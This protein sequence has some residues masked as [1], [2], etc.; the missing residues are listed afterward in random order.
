MSSNR[1]SSNFRLAGVNNNNNNND[2]NSHDYKFPF[3]NST[4]FNTSKLI[5][6]QQESMV[7]EKFA[8][9]GVQKIV[10][11][12]VKN[13]PFLIQVGLEDSFN[14]AP[15]F[16]FNSITLEAILM[17]DC[18]EDKFVDFVKH[19]PLEYKGHISEK[20]DK[21][22]IEVRIKVLTSQL[23]DM[24]FKL[25]I[26]GVDATTK[27]NIPGLVVTTQPIKVVSKQ[28]QISRIKNKQLP[29]PTQNRSSSPTRKRT[30]NQLVVD[31]LQRIEMQQTESHNLLKKLMERDDRTPSSI[32]TS[33][34]SLTPITFPS[35]LLQNLPQS[36]E[37]ESAFQHFLSVFKSVDANDRPKKIRKL[38]RDCTSKDSD[39]L[40]EFMDLT[41]YELQKDS[42][43]L[44]SPILILFSTKLPFLLLLQPKFIP[45]PISKKLTSSTVNF[46]LSPR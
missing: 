33:S 25:R 8:K 22:T 43:L 40:L 37:L 21:M 39:S 32:T 24:F 1:A 29:T 27:E 11:V 7:E 44:L 19:K 2:L 6:M 4:D 36:T 23:E 12:V 42:V 16:D 20:G 3:A 18:D 45:R 26:K 14:N 34:S 17:Y 38:V 10:H 35:K 31:A 13:T 28:E 15:S 5:I 41:R 46:Y 30:Q 9:N